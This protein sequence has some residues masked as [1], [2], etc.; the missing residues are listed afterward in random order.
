MLGF[1]KS[2]YKNIYEIS[3]IDKFEEALYEAIKFVINSVSAIAY[4]KGNTHNEKV[5]NLRAYYVYDIITNYWSEGGTGKIHS[6]AKPNRYL[7]E[8]PPRMWKT[9]LDE[10]K[11][12][13]LFV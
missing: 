12:R 13:V 6:A 2:F 1:N 3:D 8:I 5:K 9:V 4:F 11:T 7:Q 10:M